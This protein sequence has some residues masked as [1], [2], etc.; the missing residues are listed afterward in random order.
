MSRRA[1]R[2]V[3]VLDDAP[4]AT[5]IVATE[6]VSMRMVSP[7]ETVAMACGDAALAETTTTVSAGSRTTS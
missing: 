1:K 6:S 5:S 7:P 3:Y 2:I 4:F